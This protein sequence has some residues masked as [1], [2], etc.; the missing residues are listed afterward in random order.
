MMKYQETNRRS[1]LLKTLL[2]AISVALAVIATGFARQ[3]AAQQLLS[4]DKLTRFA[5]QGNNETANVLFRGGRD[6]IS[7]DQWAK[8]E[9]KFQEYIT[10]YPNEKN[11]DAAFY[12]M[13][14]SQFKLNKFDDCKITITRMLNRFPDTNWKDDARTLLAQLPNSITVNVDPMTVTVDSVEVQARV[15]ERVQERIELAQERTK[16]RTEAAQEKTKERIK[17]AQE[18]MKMKAVEKG[19]GKGIGVGAGKGVDSMS[20]DDPCEFK[21]VVLQAL[22]ESDLQRGIAAASDWLKPGSTETVQCK[23]AALGLL[24]RHGGKSV[25][26]VILGVAR[27]ESDLRLRT[28]AISVLGMSN[29]ESVIDPLRD[30]ALN[31]QQTEISEAALFALSQHTS[32]RAIGVLGEIAMSNKPVPLRKAAISSIANRSGEPAVDTLL[33]I[34]DADQSVEIRKS[35]INGLSR[36]RSERAGNKLL[37]IARGNDSV[38]LRKA[39]I[40]SLARRSGNQAIDI[41]LPLYDTEKNEELKDQIINSIGYSNDQ[42]VIRKLIEIA[43]NPREPIERRKRAIGF[44]SRSKDP[45]VLKLLEDLLKQ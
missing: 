9:Q 36:R 23:R 17:T 25:T 41:L 29:D 5:Q 7:D 3:T 45:E 1:S 10:S 16:E 20:D 37:E 14:Y 19:E 28:R 40:S 35:V 44:L 2:I 12:W 6:L 8:A 21:I 43:R 30:F 18:R 22:I 15:Q 31:S 13:A 11:V 42:R 27:N 38:E 34:Y 24:A 26:P 39:A 32:P 4:R 33:K